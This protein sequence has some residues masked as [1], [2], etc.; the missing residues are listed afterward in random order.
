MF[1]PTQIRKKAKENNQ[2]MKIEESL[3]ILLSLSEDLSA[4]NWL[5]QIF[6]SNVC[7]DLRMMKEKHWKFTEVAL[8]MRRHSERMVVI[9]NAFALFFWKKVTHY[10]SLL[11]LRIRTIKCWLFCKKCWWKYPT[12]AKTYTWAAYC[13]IIMRHG[14]STKKRSFVE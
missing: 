9:C 13:S 1:L 6:S 8:S 14:G 10:H 12:D 11:L 7:M 2:G 3:D 4:I 5:S